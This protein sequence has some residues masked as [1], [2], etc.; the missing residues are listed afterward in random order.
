MKTNKMTKRTKP[1]QVPPIVIIDPLAEHG[2]MIENALRLA[3]HEVKLTRDSHQ[4]VNL[5]RSLGAN[6]AITCLYMPGQGLGTVAELHDTFPKLSIIAF[7]TSPGSTNLAGTA[8]VFGAA[9]AMQES[10][11]P[12]DLVIGVEEMLL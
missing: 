5:C 6:A 11:Q 1:N 2:Q 12:R 8:R 10:A 7:C 3:G 4:G 9:R